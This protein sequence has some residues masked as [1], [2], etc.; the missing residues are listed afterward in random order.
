MLV[1]AVAAPLGGTSRERKVA[2]A[3]RRR[4]AYDQGNRK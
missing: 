1:V 3:L 2:E 4:Q